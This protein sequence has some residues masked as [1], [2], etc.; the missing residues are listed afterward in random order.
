[1]FVNNIPFLINMSRGIK[2][3]TIEYLSSRTSKEPNKNIKIVMKLYGRGSI[4]FQTI[5]LDMKFYFT[6]Y[7]SIWK[8]VVNTS[9]AK[10]NVAEI[11]RCI[12][13]VK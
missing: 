3:V 9:A 1:M 7:E 12:C 8:T 10:E 2:L 5:L 11:E 13:T 4:I 6:K